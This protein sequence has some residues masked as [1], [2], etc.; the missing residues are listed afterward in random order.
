[1]SDMRTTAPLK[2]DTG[3]GQAVVSSARRR[4]VAPGQSPDNARVVAHYD[5][6]RLVEKQR[7]ADRIVDVDAVRRETAA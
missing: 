7:E 6:H 3:K 2:R 1:M 5:D 4:L